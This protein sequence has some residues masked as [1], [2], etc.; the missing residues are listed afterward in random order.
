MKRIFQRIHTRISASFGRFCDHIEN[1][2]AVADALLRDG[3]RA[4]AELR[5]R[6][7][8]LQTDGQRLRQRLDEAES[9]AA[10]W[11]QRA[12]TCHAQDKDKALECIRRRKVALREVE[13][14]NDE[15]KQ[16]ESLCQQLQQS[17]EQVEARLETMRHQKNTLATRELRARV[18]SGNGEAWPEADQAEGLFDRWEVALASRETIP[19]V[20]PL[21]DLEAQFAREE[22]KTALEAELDELLAQ[23]P[24]KTEAEA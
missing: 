21:D 19:C 13:T 20:E 17:R 9:S 15:L 18:L 1:H 16:H 11:E 22:D 4:A 12:R 6:Q 24:T 3:Q 14:L 2:E 10:R 8:R 23:P 5:V 7:R